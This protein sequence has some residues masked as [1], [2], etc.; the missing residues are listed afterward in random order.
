MVYLIKEKNHVYNH[1][2]WY[3]K[4]LNINLIFNICSFK[5]IFNDHLIYMYDLAFIILVIFIICEIKSW[6][7]YARRLLEFIKVITVYNARN[8]HE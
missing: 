2:T 3:I 6:N 8:Y 4:Q 1:P 7:L 5:R